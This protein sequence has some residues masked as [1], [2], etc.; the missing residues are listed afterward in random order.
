[1]SGKTS[2]ATV[3]QGEEPP[4]LE[5]FIGYRLRKAHD[6]LMANLATT[7]EPLGLRRVLFAMLIVIRGNPGIIQMGL[8]TELG[9]QRANLVP[10]INELTARNLVD[11]QAA[12]NDRRALT[13]SLTAEGN[14]LLDEAIERVLEH[15]ERSFASLNDAERAT[16]VDLLDRVAPD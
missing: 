14:A 10:L 5:D 3:P 12:P 9:I 2:I 6:R 4:V 13:L 16:L 1:L 15:E 8:G 7:L 11:R